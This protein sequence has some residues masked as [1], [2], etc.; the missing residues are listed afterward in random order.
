MTGDATSASRSEAGTSLVE[1]VVAAVLL[2]TVT[3]AFVPAALSVDRAS[4]SALVVGAA[5]ADQGLLERHVGVAVRAAGAVLDARP[6]RLE[7]RVPSVPGT[8][9]AGTVVVFML[10]GVRLLEARTDLHEDGRTLGPTVERTLRH[11]AIGWRFSYRTWDGRDADTLVTEGV[12]DDGSMRRLLVRLLALEEPGPD[13][14]P[15]T[16]REVGAWSR[17]VGDVG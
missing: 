12:L 8:G 6:D 14:G 5:V 4:T 17:R 3:A 10:D 15:A 11:D 13:G 9:V 16:F 7:V 2:V 1:V